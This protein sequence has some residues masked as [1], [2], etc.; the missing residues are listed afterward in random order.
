MA[1]DVAFSYLP[2]S[3]LSILSFHVVKVGKPAPIHLK[4]DGA[5]T[6]TYVGPEQRSRPQGFVR[7]SL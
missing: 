4:G 7:L 2:M 5:K 3:L 6:N 1:R